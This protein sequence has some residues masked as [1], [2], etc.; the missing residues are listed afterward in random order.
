MHSA[1]P[2]CDTE[3]T[4]AKL[5]ADEKGILYRIG[6]T[7]RKLVYQTI[8]T[9][10]PLGY[11]LVEVDSDGHRYKLYTHHEGFQVIDEILLMGGYRKALDGCISVVVDIGAH[12]GVFSLLLG[13]KMS[14]INGNCFVLSI[15]PMGVSYKLLLNN[16]VLNDLEKIVLP[17]KK[18]SIGQNGEHRS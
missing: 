4:L 8:K 2:S 1:V 6:L 9:T 11:G 7:M 14:E 15:E 13:T 3:D 10:M 12:I 17:K 5:M 16:V 18:C